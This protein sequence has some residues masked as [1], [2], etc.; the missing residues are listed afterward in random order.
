MSVA[1][2][3][4]LSMGFRFLG[5]ALGFGLIWSH[6]PGWRALRTPGRLETFTSL[7]LALLAGLGTQAITSRIPG[8]GAPPG[9]VRAAI[10]GI[11][12][13]AVLLEGAGVPA[14][15]QPPPTPQA[16]LRVPM[17]VL[18]LPSSRLDEVSFQF[19]SIGPFPELVN[20]YSRFTPCFVRALRRNVQSFPN[21]ASVSLLEEVGVASVVLDARLA[22][23]TP[24]AGA[25]SRPIRGL[26]ITEAR[27]GAII[28]YE[29]P[30]RT[31][32]A[33]P[34]SGRGGVFPSCPPIG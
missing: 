2:V 3:A 10:T 25:A 31:G 19:W 32:P 18:D 34:I 11:L 21:R 24:W 16:L 17:P 20:G 5:G 15:A 14:Y 27:Y 4:V 6:A 8:A 29:L 12:L 7:G 30:R 26:G 9:G 1:V 33:M 22:A 23:G 13:T 28:V